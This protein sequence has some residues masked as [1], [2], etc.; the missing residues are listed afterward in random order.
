MNIFQIEERVKEN[1][2]SPLCVRLASL[3]LAR[4]RIDEAMK[5]CFDS[6]ERFPKYA[7]TYI[8]LGRCYAAIQQY[9]PAIIC[10]EKSLSINQDV[11]LPQKLLSNWRRLLLNNSE[12]KTL[13][14][15]E[16]QY[17]NDSAKFLIDLFNK[18]ETNSTPVYPDKIGVY[19]EPT[20]QQIVSSSSITE[21]NPPIIIS[22]TLAEIYANQGE[23]AEAI[24]MYKALMKIKPNQ[25]SLFEEKI[26]ILEEK[27]K[28]DA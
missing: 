1:P 21:I 7:T 8:V 18:S 19:H 6:I 25:K 2:A 20:S 14:I 17:I 22:S 12:R 9:E 15:F 23:Y 10:A 4:G 26:K 5:L 28:H 3:Y 24:N 16:K 13:D 11:L 27:L